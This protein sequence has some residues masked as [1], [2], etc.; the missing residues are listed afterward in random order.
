MK[1]ITGTLEKLKWYFVP[2]CKKIFLCMFFFDRRVKRSF[3]QFLS[4]SEPFSFFRFIDE[5]KCDV[6][7]RKLPQN[8]RR[9]RVDVSV[10]AL[11]PD[12]V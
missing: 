12:D 2:M 8:A 4:F 11:G 9:Y 3:Y 5:T 10:L 7:V 1:S 6:A